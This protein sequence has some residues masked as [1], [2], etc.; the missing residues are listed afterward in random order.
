MSF[1]N[2]YSITKLH[3]K[4]YNESLEFDFSAEDVYEDGKKIADI[5]VDIAENINKEEVISYFTEGGR[6][7]KDPVVKYLKQLKLPKKFTYIWIQFLKVLPK[8]RGLGKGSEILNN[9]AMNYPPGSLM[10]LSPQEVSGGKSASNIEQV[11][12]FYKQ[13]G[14]NV[15]KSSY[16]DYF[17]FRLL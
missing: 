16:G 8:Q 1:K 13:N 12:A 14:F 11:K 17:A 4:K 5:E 7:E 6:E 15:V 3:K 10:A 2:Y 9:I